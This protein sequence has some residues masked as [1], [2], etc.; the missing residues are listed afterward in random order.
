MKC[1]FRDRLLDVGWYGS[2]SNVETGYGL[3]VYQGDFRGQQLVEFR[4]RDHAELVSEVE[5]L[6]RAVMDGQL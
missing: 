6:L 5:R 4:T 3:V 1:E 2:P